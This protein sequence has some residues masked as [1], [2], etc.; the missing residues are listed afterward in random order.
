MPMASDDQT[1]LKALQDSGQEA[2]AGVFSQHSP[3]LERTVRFRLDQRLWRR[4]DPADVLQEAYLEAAQRLPGYLNEP[5][6][7]VFVW[8]RAVTEQTPVRR[9][10]GLPVDGCA[11][12]PPCPTRWVNTTYAVFRLLCT[13]VRV[14][15]YLGRSTTVHVPSRAIRP[16]LPG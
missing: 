3:R 6:V 2:L 5:A 14:L 4:V 15:R 9:Y 16:A 10:L 12:Q 11:Q 13:D 7:P 1:D 8:L